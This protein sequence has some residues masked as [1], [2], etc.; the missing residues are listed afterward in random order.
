M[1]R[2]SNGDGDGYRKAVN[3]FTPE[4]A[5]EDFGV[6]EEKAEELLIELEEEGVMHYNAND[7]VWRLGSTMKA[8]KFLVKNRKHL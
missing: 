1:F 5:A 8:T 3:G 4:A 7:E 6:S 2:K